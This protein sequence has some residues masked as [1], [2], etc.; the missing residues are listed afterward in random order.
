MVETLPLAR[1][2]KCRLPVAK[3]LFS[4][5]ILSRNGHDSHR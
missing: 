4:I 1:D 3:H 5:D 2:F